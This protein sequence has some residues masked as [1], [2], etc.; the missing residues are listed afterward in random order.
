MKSIKEKLKKSKYIY[1]F[2]LS[3]LIGV[4]GWGIVRLMHIEAAISPISIVQPAFIASNTPVLTVK[5][6]PK[7]P[8]PKKKVKTKSK[9][10][11]PRQKP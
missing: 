3:L 8:V 9:V 10:T 7:T 1:G 6:N 5:A 4:T 2:S 11:K